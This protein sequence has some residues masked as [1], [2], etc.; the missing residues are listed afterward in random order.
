MEILHSKSFFKLSKSIALIGYSFCLGSIASF[1]S[2]NIIASDSPTIEFFYW[3]RRFVNPIMDFVTMPGIWLLLI[4]NFGLFLQQKNKI[5]ALLLFLSFLVVLNGQFIIIPLAKLVSNLAIKQFQRS[6]M[7]QD[8]TA[9]KLIEDIC[10]GINLI[11]VL[12]YLVV[13]I[14]HIRKPDDNIQSIS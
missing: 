12:I 1:I 2:M 9:N 5:N 13:Y 6:H 4:G 8:F 11:F 3:Q 10:G 7:I 14:F